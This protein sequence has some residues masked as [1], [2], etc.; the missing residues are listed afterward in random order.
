M[1]ISEGLNV[2]FP[3]SG[4]SELPR[5][6]RVLCLLMAESSRWLTVN[7]HAAAYLGRRIEEDRR[8]AS[9]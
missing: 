3:E 2:C 8:R 6:E 9:H 4:R 7:M 5:W 1:S